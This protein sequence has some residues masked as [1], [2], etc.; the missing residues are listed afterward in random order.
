MLRSRLSISTRSRY[1]SN[2]VIVFDGGGG[3]RCRQISPGFESR[4]ELHGH[5]QEERRQFHAARRVPPTT[6]VWT[7]APCSSAPR[8]NARAASAKEFTLVNLNT[9]AIPTK[10]QAAVLAGNDAAAKSRHRQGI[11]SDGS[12]RSE[13]APEG[14]QIRRPDGSDGQRLQEGDHRWLTRPTCSMRSTR[15]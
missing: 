3:C 14:P 13:H 11:R 12:L 9:G 5:R 10:E 6:P 8:S 7:S 4:R 2:P 1:Q 15:R